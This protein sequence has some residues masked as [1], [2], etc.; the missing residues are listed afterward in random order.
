MQLLMFYAFKY[1]FEY[2]IVPKYISYESTR[3]SYTTWPKIG[4]NGRSLCLHGKKFQC[5]HKETIH[6]V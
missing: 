5:R 3:I 4:I 6:I 2:K 1:A